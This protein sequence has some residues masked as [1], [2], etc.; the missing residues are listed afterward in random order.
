MNL[1]MITIRRI[2]THVEDI[3]HEFGPPAGTSMAARRRCAMSM[4]TGCSASI[5]GTISS[6]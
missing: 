3:H 4:P 1:D 5:I 2:V 6:T